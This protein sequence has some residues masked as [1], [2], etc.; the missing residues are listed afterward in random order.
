MPAST[1]PSPAP[2]EPA[3]ASPPRRILLVDADAFFVAVARQEDPEGAGRATLLIV[4]GR[5]GSRGVVCSASYECRA[6]GVRSAMSIAQALKLCPQAMCVPVPR[7]AC[8]RRS[9][10]IQ[11]V[12]TRFAPVVQA[13]SIDEWYCDLAGT[14]ALYGHEPLDVTAHRIRDAVR[15][16]TGLNVSIGGGTT[17]LVAKMAVE[18]AKPKPGTTANGVCCV[19]DGQEAAFLADFRLADIPMVG[20]RFAERLTQLGLV[21]VRDAQAWSEI[22]LTTRLGARAGA[23]L[24]RKVRGLDDSIVVARER[25]KQ[26]S[27]EETFG[28]DIGDDDTLERELLR[29][30]VRVSADLRKQALRA[31]TVTVKLRD[32]DFRTRSAQRTLPRGIASERAVVNAARPLLAQLRDK[33]RTKARLLGIA[34]SHFDAEDGPGRLPRARQLALFEDGPGAPRAAGA[35]PDSASGRSAPAPGAMGGETAPP[36]DGPRDEALTAALDRIR[37]R[38]GSESI[39]PARLLG[40]RSTGPRVEE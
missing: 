16:E 22:A 27:R 5:P 40:G 12:L 6:Y 15:A 36:S 8:S 31:R 30:A 9:K 34:L 28:R 39:V 26:V 18:R 37:E 38:F 4:G 13:S 20:P 33:R 35:T 17:R 19:P 29:L 3:A 25:Q 7:G 14:E 2:H 23:W 10:D 24:Y 21:D 11:A 32:A 1:P